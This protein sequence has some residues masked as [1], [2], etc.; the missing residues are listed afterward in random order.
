MVQAELQAPQC[1]LLVRMSVSQ[2]LATLLSQLPKPVLHDTPQLLAVHEGV[3]LFVEHTVV[4]VPQC[5][6]SE[7]RFTS[8]PL[9]ALLSQ[10]PKPE[11][12]AMLQLPIEHDGVPLVAEHA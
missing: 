12:H 3:L 11:L 6:T 4:Q 7:V 1:V 5:R 10:L 8:Q 2:P 9:L